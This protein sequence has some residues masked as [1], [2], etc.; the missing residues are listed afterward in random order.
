MKNKLIY[1]LFIIFMFMPFHVMASDI[2]ST[3]I[4][5]DDSVEVGEEITQKFYINFENVKTNDQNSLGLWFVSFELIYDESVLELI[6]IES[7]DWLSYAAKEGTTWGVASF[8]YEEFTPSNKCIDGENFCGNY[9]VELKFK[10]LNNSKSTTKISMGEIVALASNMYENDELTITGISNYEKTISIS[11]KQEEDKKDDLEDIKDNEEEEKEDNSEIE[12]VS[13]SSN[14]YLESLKIE[15]YE[16]DFNKYT[17]EYEIIIEEEKQNEAL[18]INAV[19][20]H[21]KSKVIIIGA[22]N[23]YKYNNKVEIVVLAENGMKNT[24]T[25]NIKIN[26]NDEDLDKE[27]TEKKETKKFELTDEHLMIGGIVLGALFL[28]IIIRFIIIKINDRKID[29]ALD[30]L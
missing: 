15:G 28:I 13:K 9:N 17:N 29:K 6:E 7:P 11:S 25:I 8:L 19:A 4:V 16:L 3:S 26:M 18:K 12:P 10:V 30:D 5:G 1:M 23:F 27:L 24:Y 20:E 14:R 2:K 22:D 21:E